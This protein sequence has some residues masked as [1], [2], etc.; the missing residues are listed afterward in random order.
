MASQDIQ[1]DGVPPCPLFPL[2]NRSGSVARHRHLADGI[3]K[4]AFIAAG[5]NGKLAPHSLRKSFAQRVSNKSGAIYWVQA[6]LG[7]RSVSTPQ[8]S[9]GVSDASA[10]HAVEAIALRREPDRRPLLSRSLKNTSDETLLRELARR[11]YHPARL[12]ENTD[13]QAPV[14]IVKI[15]AAPR[16]KHQK[17]P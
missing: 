12:R 2:R 6:R 4:K 3:V 11:G 17:D 7:H 5:F 8:K 10:R 14:E 15:G 16:K 1:N 9:M 13:T